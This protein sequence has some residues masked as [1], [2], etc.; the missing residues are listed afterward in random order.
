VGDGG[1]DAGGVEGRRGDEGE[2]GGE[3]GVSEAEGKGGLGGGGREK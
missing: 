3:E 2:A 1:G